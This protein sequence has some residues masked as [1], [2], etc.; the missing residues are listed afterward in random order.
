MTIARTTP[1]EDLPQWLTIEEFRIYLCLGRST[2]YDL[3]N[4]DQV[5]HKRF[6]RVIRI[7]REAVKDFGLKKEA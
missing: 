4:R 5:A 3:V 6:G 1:F 7:P 2:V